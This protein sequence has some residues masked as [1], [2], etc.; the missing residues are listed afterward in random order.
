MSNTS[1][2][3]GKKIDFYHF[4]FRIFGILQRRLNMD[5]SERSN[6]SS[7]LQDSGSVR[8]LVLKP[9]LSRPEVSMLA[10]KFSNLEDYGIQVNSSADVFCADGTLLFSYRRRV[11]DEQQLNEVYHSLVDTA[12][13]EKTQRRGLAMGESISGVHS[14][15]AGFWDQQHPRM[16]SKADIPCRLSKF[17]REHP[18]KWDRVMPLIDKVGNLYQQILPI[19]YARQESYLSR[20][21]EWRI[22]PVFTTITVNYNW[23]TALHVD[24]G[25]LKDGVSALIVCEQGEWHGGLLGFPRYGVCV[26][27][28]QGDLLLMNPHEY[29]G[30]TQIRYD[31]ADAVRLS[32]V[33]YARQ[34]I[35]KCEKKSLVI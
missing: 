22:N 21:P 25:D 26:D 17:S 8:Q 20:V 28:R 32:I 34:G 23:R 14:M 27:V 4:N 19:Q 3:R 11:L 2:E 10:G 35:R 24:K 13:K 7:S 33:A 5:L 15:I 16:A 1:T 6:G 9:L 29:H 18:L 30:N 12:R 31:S